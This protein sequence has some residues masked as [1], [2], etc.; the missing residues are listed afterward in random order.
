MKFYLDLTFIR[1]SHRNEILRAINVFSN[2][3]INPYEINSEELPRY[4]EFEFSGSITDFEDI[5][6]SSLERSSILEYVVTQDLLKENT[7]T[8]LKP[9]NLEQLDIYFCDFCGAFFNS[10]EGKYIHERAH[11]FY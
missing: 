5:V 3:L 8:L 11:Y 1:G 6:R 10:E 4:V 9:G 7:F 2:L